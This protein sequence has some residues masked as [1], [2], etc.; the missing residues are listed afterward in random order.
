MS[1]KKNICSVSDDLKCS[2]HSLILP[3]TVKSVNCSSARTTP[4]ANAV[5]GVANGSTGHQWITQ[6]SHAYGE[7][8]I[9]TF[10]TPFRVNKARLKQVDAT[11]KQ[12][13]TLGVSFTTT[14][15]VWLGVSTLNL[16]HEYDAVIKVIQST[17]ALRAP[18]YYGHP[19]IKDRS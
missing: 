10:V 13:K 15:E 4:C 3:P 6:S 2:P 9:V 18:R 5:D 7:W 14:D 16:F 17:L 11:H 19:A 1:K 8:F 12:I